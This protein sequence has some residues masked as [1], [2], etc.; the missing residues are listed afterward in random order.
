[1]VKDRIGKEGEREREREKQCVIPPPSPPPLNS[2]GYIV[3]SFL[4]YNSKQ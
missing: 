1:M 2:M 4:L 3:Y